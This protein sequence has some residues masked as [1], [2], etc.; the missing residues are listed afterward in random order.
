MPDTRP[1]ESA[2]GRGETQFDLECRVNA[3]EVRERLEY[4]TTLSE[5]LRERLGLTGTKVSCAEEICGACTVLLDGRPVSS[6]TTLAYEAIG[7]DVTTIEG[8]GTPEDLHPL[9]AAFID[10]FA[11]QCGFCTPGMIMSALALLAER[12]DADRDEIINHMD[13]NICR[14]TGYV[15]ILEAIEQAR[16]QLR[17]VDVDE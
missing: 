17:A 15:P 2:R 6:C 12:P 10:R 9:Q 14:C 5:L 8:V 11:M 3:G 4:S 1:H 13:G 16:D 7:G